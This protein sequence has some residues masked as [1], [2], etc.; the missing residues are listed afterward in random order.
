MRPALSELPAAE[1][2]RPAGLI[3]GGRSQRNQRD[4]RSGLALAAKTHA[5]QGGKVCDPV[6]QRGRCSVGM[7]YYLWAGTTIVHSESIPKLRNYD[8]K[9]VRKL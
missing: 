4:L 1:L 3:E 9:P 8:N 6:L 5:E 7:L 2:I